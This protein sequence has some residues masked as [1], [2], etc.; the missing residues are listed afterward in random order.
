MR[1]CVCM[2]V[3]AREGRSTC[4]AQAEEIGALNALAL[5]I[6]VSLVA[7]LFLK[8]AD[9]YREAERLLQAVQ[10]AHALRP[11]GR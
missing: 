6:K 10:C 8:A 2:C 3:R 1:V 7:K 9:L 4:L 5:E 11:L